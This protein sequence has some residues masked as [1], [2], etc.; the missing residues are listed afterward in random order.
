MVMK[1]FIY[2]SS[3]QQTTSS[4]PRE[5]PDAPN[6]QSQKYSRNRND[7]AGCTRMRINMMTVL[8]SETDMSGSE[9]DCRSEGSQTGS[10]TGSET[11]TRSEIHLKF[12]E[13]QEETDP[14]TESAEETDPENPPAYETPDESGDLDQ[15]TVP[16]NNQAIALEWHP[17]HSPPVTQASV[18]KKRNTNPDQPSI[19]QPQALEWHPTG[20]LTVVQTNPLTLSHT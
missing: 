15:P 4:L 13:E 17:I 18:P 7:N 14:Q 8:E 9:R 1:W 16:G 19:L 20:P 5:W 11:E 3:P 6:G 2:Q 10:E 12:A